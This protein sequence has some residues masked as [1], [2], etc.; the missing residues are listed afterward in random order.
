VW[1]VGQNVDLPIIGRG[2]IASV[3]DVIDFCAAGAVAVQLDSIL[4]VEPGAFGDIYAGLVGKLE[5]RGLEWQAF[6]ELCSSSTT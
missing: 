3:E 5:Q 2:G 6:R 4:Y 1:E